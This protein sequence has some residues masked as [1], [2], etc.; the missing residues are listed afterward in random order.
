MSELMR[1]NTDTALGVTSGGY[2]PWTENGRV[3]KQI[4]RQE[5]D[6]VMDM[7]GLQ[8][9]NEKDTLRQLQEARLDERAV[10]NGQRIAD[11]ALGGVAHH[12]KLRDEYVEQAKYDLSAHDI[13]D[14][15]KSMMAPL[16]DLTNK[17][18]QNQK[19]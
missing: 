4:S 12:L 16:A 1:R 17:S 9:Q 15:S 7:I 6:H 8:H 2:M 14:F 19:R 11:T 5:T 3:A 13:M 18:I 10:I